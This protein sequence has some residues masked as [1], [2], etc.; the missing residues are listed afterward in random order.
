MERIDR[1][2]LNLVPLIGAELGRELAQLAH[3]IGDYHGLAAAP[4]RVRSHGRGYRDRRAG[5][6]YLSA[7]AKALST[8]GLV[9]V[10]VTRL[11]RR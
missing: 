5:Q 7:P 3:R 11:L 8:A 9:A 2:T 10:L 6:R 1:R 4:R